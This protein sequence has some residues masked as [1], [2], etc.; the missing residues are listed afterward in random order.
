LVR[1]CTDALLSETGVTLVVH[2]KPKGEDGNAQAD[3]I[4]A[5]VAAVGLY[6]SNSVYP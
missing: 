2:E 5:V 6:K 1:T 4:L 3:E